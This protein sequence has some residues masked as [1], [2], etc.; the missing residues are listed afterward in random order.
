MGQNTAS[1]GKGST[2]G[3][4]GI[5]GTSGDSP[6]PPFGKQGGTLPHRGAAQPQALYAYGCEVPVQP[7]RELITSLFSHPPGNILG[8]SLKRH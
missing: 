2:D 4:S 1:V 6:P 7:Q 8:A 5:Q 3:C